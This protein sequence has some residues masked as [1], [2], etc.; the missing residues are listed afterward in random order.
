MNNRK[1]YFL[2]FAVL[3]MNLLPFM[4]LHSQQNTI[5]PLSYDL[6]D[7]D[8]VNYVT[9]IK[10][11][12]GGT[13]WTHG[14]M[15]AIEGNL[16]MTGTW[17]ESNEEGEPNLAEY[18]LDWWNGFNK[19]WN[20]DLNPSNGYG[21]DP[22]MGGDYRVTAAYL[23]RGDGA[24]RDIDGQ[25]YYSAPKRR[26]PN[27]HY[28]YVRDIEWYYMNSGLENIETIKEK[29][30]THGVMGTCLFSN[31]EFLDRSNF[32]HYQPPLS[33]VPPNHAVAIIGW[34]D[35]KATR[36]SNN[37]AWLC[38]NSWDVDWGI[39]GYFWISY[40]DKHAG[41]DKEMGAVSF[42][43]VEPMQY[44]NIYFHDYHGWRD[45]M[46]ECMEAFNTFE[47]R[48]NETIKAVSF[49]VAADQVDFTIRIFD[50]YQNDQLL[51][52][53]SM[54]SGRIDY[55]G[56]HTIDLD[57]PVSMSEGD[58]FYV[59]LYL[60]EGGHPYDR[61]SDVPVL[62]GANYI[63][64]IVQSAA[65]PGESY[66]YDGNSWVDFF[67]YSD[68]T[69][70]D[71]INAIGTTNFCIKALT[72]DST[73]DSDQKNDDY[74][75]DFNLYQNYPN[76]FNPSTTIHYQLS[77]DGHVSLTVYNLLGEEVIKLIDNQ[78]TTG[79][80]QITWDGRDKYMQPVS[81]GMYIYQLRIGDRFASKKMM[82][83]R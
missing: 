12:Q 64:T 28:Y 48:S 82:L 4:T 9:S 62:L 53:L 6:R 14:A 55:Q 76:P 18:H 15:A 83:V 23:S 66:Y 57:T 74:P 19:H 29:I 54:I 2:I 43:N 60:S 38:K 75:Q 1:I 78:Q 41:R 25:S 33:S 35:K 11:Q 20:P 17:A 65:N 58:D 7:V 44:D 51:N 71:E 27:Y 10:S 63:G 36:A 26:D 21:L 42:Q 3:S 16:L 31:S 49:F 68:P 22:H 67:E 61:T 50:D 72:I 40:Y 32:T 45:T 79:T 59:Y 81:S 70:P 46:E 52:E 73:T 34:D 56:F 47:A 37:G 69:W 13:C 77:K 5:L 80:Y 8:G 30:M 24:V 39:N